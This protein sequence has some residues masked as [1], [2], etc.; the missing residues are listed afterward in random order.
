MNPMT[1][2]D[3][4]L[5]AAVRAGDAD[6]EAAFRELYRRYADRVYRY[7]L[8][9]VNGDARAAD[10][11]QDT[12]MKFLVVLRNGELIENVPAFLMRICRNLCL[13]LRRNERMDFID[14]QLITLA[15]EDESLE[16]RDLQ[17]HLSAA[18]ASLPDH[19]REALVMHVYGGLSYAEICEAT[20][21]S[22]PM[23]RNRISRARQW[24]RSALLP[25]FRN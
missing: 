19:Y 12:F 5:M 13:D 20:E 2:P 18:I 11:L 14:P 10:I 16:D 25:L 21:S 4:E 1:T 7:A 6:C 17:E 9:V 23:V 3:N 15:T 8:K 24:L 22:L